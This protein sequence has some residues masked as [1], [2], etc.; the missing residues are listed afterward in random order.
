MGVH[1]SR[2]QSLT[3]DNIGT[4]Q[5]LIAR[6]MSNSGFNDIMEASC[7]IKTQKPKPTSTM[8][9]RNFFIRS[10]YIQKNFIIRTCTSESEL[11]NDLEQAVQTKDFFYL[12]QVWAEG[13]IL[14]SHLPSNTVGETALH[15]AVMNHCDSYSLHI[16]DFIIQNSSNLNTITRHEGNTALHYC[17]IYNRSECMKLLLRSK[18]DYNIKN[19][20][21]KT[22]L[23]IAREEHNATL[24]ELVSICISFFL[25]F[26][27]HIILNSLKAL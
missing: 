23:D 7:N 8:E 20:N 4:S 24:I 21:G 26:L 14:T 10:K 19:A 12:L 27:I 1:I 16:V 11:L 25:I 15:Y 18:A 5:L 6:V 22:P 3:L 2:I 9:E 13:A 17:V